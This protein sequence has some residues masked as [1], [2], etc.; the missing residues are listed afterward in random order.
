MIQSNLGLRLLVAAVGIPVGFLVVWTGGWVLGAAALLFALGGAWEFIGIAR[1]GG[2]RP[3]A[4]IVLPSTA[5]LVGLA[6]WT[7]SYAAWSGLALAVL[8]LVAFVSL[9]LTLR[10]R[11]TNGEPLAGVGSTLL[12]IVY[13]AL[14]FAFVPFLREHPEAAAVAPGW[15]GTFLVVF[16]LMVTWLGDSSAY[17]GGR[18]WGN[19]KLFP[20]VSPSKTV[21]GALTGLVGSVIGGALVTAFLL[22]VMGGGMSLSIAGGAAF[23]LLIGVVGQLGDL[24]ESLLK[25]EAGVKDSGTFLP[26]HGGILDRFD[27]VLFTL[28]LTYGALPL[29]LGWGF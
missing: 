4:W 5:L 23:A 27:A 13:V 25:R 8:L 21:E 28:P 19:R 29:F 10:Y 11:G 15:A 1:A 26:G 20:S 2:R 22:P 17:F 12:G 6:V 18:F 7:G 14:P 3:F 24:V 9:L 16:P